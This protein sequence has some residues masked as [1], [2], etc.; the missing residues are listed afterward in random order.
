MRSESTEQTVF[1]ARV[2]QFHPDAMIL[3]IPNGG[4]RDA[5][6][7]AQMKRE[8]VL[9]GAP[10]L[11]VPEPRGQW[12]GLFIEMKRQDGRTSKEQVIVHQQLAERGYKVD[13]CHG[14]DHAY[15]AFLRYVYGNDCL[16]QFPYA[17]LLLIKSGVLNDQHSG[18]SQYR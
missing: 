13:V 1:V 15:M 12:H 10:D 4:R 16:K 11:F 8:G 5:R 7:A 18:Q 6:A 17:R 2:R 9:P 3:S 14:A